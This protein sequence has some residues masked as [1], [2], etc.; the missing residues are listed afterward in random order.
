[1]ARLARA[2]GWQFIRETIREAIREAI[3]DGM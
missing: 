2:H 3:Q 1:M